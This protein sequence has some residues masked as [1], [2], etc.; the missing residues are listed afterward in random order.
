LVVQLNFGN[1]LAVWRTQMIDHLI[2]SVAGQPQALVSC[3]PADAENLGRFRNA[4]SLDIAKEK[5]LA[6]TP[7]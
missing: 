3:G 6:T 7:P 1:R 5:H 4:V 2:H